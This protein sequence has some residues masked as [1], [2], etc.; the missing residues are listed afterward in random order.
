MLCSQLNL[1]VAKYGDHFNESQAIMEPSPQGQQHHCWRELPLIKTASEHFLRFFGKTLSD[2]DVEIC[3]PD[4][5]MT[6]ITD[7]TNGLVFPIYDLHAIHTVE[8]IFDNSQ[9]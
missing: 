8:K 2:E 5:S 4:H 1:F 3:L 6:S 7:L 9:R